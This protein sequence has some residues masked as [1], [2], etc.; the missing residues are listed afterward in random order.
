[1]RMRAVF[2]FRINFLGQHSIS[3]VSLVRSFILPE[4]RDECGLILQRL[5]IEPT[6][7]SK[8]PLL[9]QSLKILRFI[10]TSFALVGLVIL[11]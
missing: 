10:P 9:V 3:A 5:V 6:L 11:R 2:L 8:S 7:N 4:E 1:M